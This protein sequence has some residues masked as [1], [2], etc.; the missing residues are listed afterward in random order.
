MKKLMLLAIALVMTSLAC[1]KDEVQGMNASRVSTDLHSIK[2]SK[3]FDWKTTQMV[4][5]N[6]KGAPEAISD[7]SHPI[8]IK[9]NM[10]NVILTRM[11]D[12]QKNDVIRMRM[13]KATTEITMQ[14]GAISKKVAISHGQADF[15]YYPKDQVND[16][17]LDDPTD[18]AMAAPTN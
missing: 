8:T 11:V 5:I 14:Y 10:G 2:V 1:K 3:D 17:V 15:D 4:T 12:I 13:P 18:K 6:I 16:E 9:D 7:K